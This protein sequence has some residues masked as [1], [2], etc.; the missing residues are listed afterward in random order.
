MRSLLILSIALLSAATN[1]AAQTP[2][3]WTISAGPEWT[4]YR[5]F[6]GVRLRADYD[7]LKQN[8]PFQLRMQGGARWGPTQSYQSSYVIV[9]GSVMGQEQTV[10]LMFGVVGAISP[11]PRARFSPYVT[12]GVLARQA[13]SHG[14]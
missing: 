12:A 11:L 1:G 9:G 13:W 2:S 14:W 6:W 3:R 7:L 5:G 10:D 8:S 4:V